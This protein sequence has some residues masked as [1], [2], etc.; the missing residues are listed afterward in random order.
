MNMSDTTDK[1]IPV[2]GILSLALAPLGLLLI[3]YFASGAG[4]GV[5][6]ARRVIVFA[7]YLLL[8]LLGSGLVSGVAGMVRRERPG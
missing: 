6:H 3:L 5:V 4:L 2:W 7:Q 1:L 8:I